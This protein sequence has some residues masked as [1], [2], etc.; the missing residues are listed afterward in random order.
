MSHPAYNKVTRNWLSFEDVDLPL[1]SD[2]VVDPTFIDQERCMK[3]GADYWLYNVN[4]ISCMTDEQIDIDPTF[5]AAAKAG[6]KEEV[7]NLR[8]GKFDHFAWN[9]HRWNA[10]D[11]SKTNVTGAVVIAMMNSGNLPPDFTWRCYDNMN[12]EMTGTDMMTLGAS[13]GTYGT[14]VYAASWVHKTNIDALTSITA[15]NAYDITTGWP[16]QEP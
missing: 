15:V 2:W 6:K 3:F 12:H 9:G 4:E 5:L 8:E 13:M 1:N 10:D 11:K 16:A 14:Q 7:S